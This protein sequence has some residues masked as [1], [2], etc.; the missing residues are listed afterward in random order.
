MYVGNHYIG[1]IYRD[2][3]TTL[4]YI[5]RK[6]FGGIE[7]WDLSL[8]WK[9]DL[10][11]IAMPANALILAVDNL[12]IWIVNFSEQCFVRKVAV[13][14]FAT[15]AERQIALPW[16]LWPYPP[17]TYPTAQEWA[18]SLWFDPIRSNNWHTTPIP[19][20]SLNTN[21]INS[22]WSNG[23]CLK[24]AAGCAKHCEQIGVRVLT[25]ALHR[26]RCLCSGV[27]LVDAI[28]THFYHTR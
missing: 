8:R 1:C 16:R 19:K 25:R 21:E 18:D 28:D 15:I 26:H 11:R 10:A 17:P 12:F 4:C 14:D 7:N 22:M 5:R 20:E 24:F 23:V 13:A 27:T 9:E 2:T 6:I 3:C